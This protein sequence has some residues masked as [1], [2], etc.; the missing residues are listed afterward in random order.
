V[1]EKRA[2]VM[3][4]EKV[5]PTEKTDSFGV[6]VLV[7]IAILQHDIY[8]MRP[9]KTTQAIALSIDDERESEEETRSIAQMKKKIN[10]PESGTREE[11][12]SEDAEA[13]IE[14]DVVDESEE[15][16]E[17]GDASVP[18]EPH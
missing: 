1:P 3:T 8:M 2:N 13:D 14:E 11:A 10:D 17:E 16:E 7:G 4:R 6:G 18:A 15:L 9:I 5:S 12:Q